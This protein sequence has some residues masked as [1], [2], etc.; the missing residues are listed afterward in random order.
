MQRCIEGFRHKAVHITATWL[1]G[2]VMSDRHGTALTLLCAS[3]AWEV[4]RQYNNWILLF[5]PAY[6]REEVRERE[7]RPCVRVPDD[8]I[9]F[10]VPAARVAYQSANQ[11]SKRG[12]ALSQRVCL[13]ITIFAS[14]HVLYWRGH[15]APKLF[16]TNIGTQSVSA[17]II[18]TD[19]FT[20]NWQNKQLSK[21]T[22][23]NKL[24]LNF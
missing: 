22:K 5:K 19:N 23:Q 17:R 21:F 13:S 10:A 6:L 14:L 24:N 18:I 9:A 15:E 16:S 11:L 1:S 8:P 3:R 7:A 4:F 20:Y 12:R 2:C